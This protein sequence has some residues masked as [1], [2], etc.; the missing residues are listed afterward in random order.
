MINLQYVENATVWSLGFLPVLLVESDIEWQ[1][2]FCVVLLWYRSA[3]SHSWPYSLAVIL[4]ARPA[5]AFCQLSERGTH[6]VWQTRQKIRYGLADKETFFAAGTSLA[7][8]GLQQAL[9][10]D[11]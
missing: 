6:S 2:H 11:G 10:I 4:G 9:L 3:F 7:S 1:K 5:D 8:E